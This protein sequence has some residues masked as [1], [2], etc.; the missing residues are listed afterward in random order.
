MALLLTTRTIAA[1]VIDYQWWREMG[2]VTTW[3]GMMAYNIAPVAGAALLLFAVLWI[4]LARGVKFAGERLSAHRTFS[5]LATL[6]VLVV[7]I[8]LSLMLVDSWTIVRYL[9]SRTVPPG[10]WRDPVFG[11]A[12]GFFSLPF[13]SLLLRYVL[14]ASIA[15]A[16]T[17]WI[18]ARIWQLGGRLLEARGDNQI[19]LSNFRLEG[20]LESR[21]LRTV[22]AIFF[23]G[24][25]VR[26]YL[27]RYDTLLDDH[28]F[29]VGADWVAVHLSIPLLYVSAGAAVLAAV[30]LLLGRYR[31]ALVLPAAMLVQFILP[32]LVG[33]VYVRPNEI[34][35]ERP[36]IQ[37]H[38][39]STRSAF[40]L[41]EGTR[42]VDFP[43]KLEAPIDPARHQALLSNVRLWDWRAFHD[44]VSQ[45]QSLR[46]YYVFPDTDV[47]RYTIDGQLRQVMLSPREIDVRQLGNQG[48]TRWINSHFIYTHG[49]GMVM[50]SANRITSEGMP[51]F[52]IQDVPPVVNTPSLK[53]TRPEIYFGEA[54]TQPVFV[55]TGQPEFNYPSGSDNVHTSYQGK[56]GFPIGSFPLRLAA[57][58]AEGDPNILLTGY[59]KG[60]SRLMIHRKVVD[61]VNALADF[62]QWD[63]DPYLV[64]A[65]SGRLVWILD[66]YTTSDSHP[67]SRSTQFRGYR[68]IN[69]IRNS[70][71]ATVDAYDGE[72]RLYVFD[73]ADPVIQS[74]VRL[75]P[76]LFAAATEMPADLRRH[77]RYP[78]DLFK[79]QAETYRIYHMRDPEAF[80]NKEDVWDIAQTGTA[81]EGRAEAATPTYVVAALPDE[82]KAEFMLM[83]PFAPRNKNNLIGV[84][85]ARCDGESYGKKVVLKLSKQAQINGPLQIEAKIN[86][87]QNISKDLTLWNQQGSQ[88]LRG[89]MLVLPVD[90]TFLYV[91]PIYIQASQASMPQLKKVALAIG[92]RI[93]YADT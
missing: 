38:I 58:L 35:L 64:L 40:G 84:M 92:N 55:R 78:E 4:G 1:F 30:A 56:G 21:F 42:E 63:Q 66:G 87:D 32:L 75:F 72:T 76:R 51:V 11:E 24:L 26:F 48:S 54:T 74:Y 15:A 59:L 67:Y 77:I 93:I 2:Q 62:I 18:S 69:Y 36:Y 29:L 19:D 7:A 44:T 20:G 81:A 86:Q 17:Y 91:E 39:E 12:L 71:K 47:D 65:D 79:V 8:I 5:R 60:E 57:A 27:D 43:A 31:W 68:G 37:Q 45:V 33:S 53:I 89:Q 61:R 22:A 13:Y 28:G 50:A 52:Y 34:S 80:Y 3:F 9:G 70:I 90:N 82:D 49:Y 88:V 10:A 6:A 41:A 46:T 83:L 73:N 25:A 23:L 14:G 85:M 16:L